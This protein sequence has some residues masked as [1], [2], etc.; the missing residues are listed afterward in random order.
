[1]NMP[2]ELIYVS[3]GNIPSLAANSMQVVKMA[4]AIRELGYNIKLMIG[5][6][7]IVK[8]EKRFSLKK[9]YGLKTD[10]FFCKMPVSFVGKIPYGT[11][12]VPFLYNLFVKIYLVL[13]RHSI[14]I[15]TRQ[16]EVAEF[17]A[18]LDIPF[19]IELHNFDSIT[20]DRLKLLATSS[21][22]CC[23]VVISEPLRSLYS[24][25]LVGKKIITCHDGV[26]ISEY[27]SVED[28][29]I[30]NR[31]SLGIDTTS[32]KG[33]CV[34]T[35]HLYE[36]RGIEE[37]LAIAI[38]N[39]ALLFL[40]VGGWEDDVNRYSQYCEY[41]A[42]RNAIFVGHVSHEK[43]VIYQKAAD[44]LLMPYPS[45]LKTVDVCS[46]LKLFEYMAT[47]RPIVATRLP[48]VVEILGSDY[49]Y[50]A[51]MDDTDEL[52]EKIFY[53]LDGDVKANQIAKSM[54]E[55]ARQ[56]SWTNRGKKIMDFFSISAEIEKYNNFQSS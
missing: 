44:V 43:V 23:L 55:R 45:R 29:K 31:S 18:R 42:I 10:D 53:A 37:L 14:A 35:G 5:Y 38:K 36:D 27:D 46:P 34:Y 9:W 12:R 20:A 39:P 54:Y 51:G 8:G 33:V 4:S 48:N 11:G 40:F 49:P 32:Y 30:K 15:F 24:Q 25:Y 22:L 50:F 56:Y 6:P 2:R 17:A 16:I 3:K 13:H 41:H 26:D 21:S 52:E 47:K 7:L 1:M 19:A 28:D